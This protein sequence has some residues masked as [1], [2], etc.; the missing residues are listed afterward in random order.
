L[1]PRR[2]LVLYAIDALFCLVV[3]PFTYFWYEEWDEESTLGSRVRGALKY[4][5]LF[6]LITLALLLTGFFIP[7]SHDLT[8][9]IDLDYLKR[10]LSENHGEKALSFV[11]GVLLSLGMVFYIVY[12]APGFA[13]FPIHLIKRVPSVQISDV[14]TARQALEH[15]RECQRRIEIKYQGTGTTMSVKDRKELEALQ[16][17]ERTLTR[18]HRLAEESGNR[19]QWWVRLGSALSPFRVAFGIMLALLGI[20]IVI[21]M[22]L[23]LYSPLCHFWGWR[24]NLE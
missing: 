3:I 6:L 4:S 12:T 24:S 23:T 8:G 13:L 16:R 7:I 9:G 18:R 15:N 14:D 21:S 1:D 10:L 19:R 22:G 5:V 17:E 2:P 20:L 11:L